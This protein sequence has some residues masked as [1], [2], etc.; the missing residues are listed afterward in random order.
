VFPKLEWVDLPIHTIL[1]Q[2]AES[3]DYGY[4]INSGLTSILTVMVDGKSVDVGLAGTEGFV[5]MPLVAGFKSSPTRAIVQIHGNAF[6]I[7]AKDLARVLAECP[8]LERRLQ[9]HAQQM[10]LQSAQTAACNQLHNLD[11]R[12][13]TWLL[14]R[15]D[16]VGGDVFGLT[17]EFLALMLGMRR[18]SVTDAMGV[19]Q[20]TR[21]V[22]YTRGKVRINNR[23]G[24]K[25][26]ACE[27]YAAINRQSDK[28]D[29]ESA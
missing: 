27:C 14:M 15:Q 13:A 10:S 16:R 18:A 5:G 17:Q 4:F 7:K 6:R 11:Q 21:L 20:K 3:I 2:V 28:W 22:T 23:A 1:N 24:L 8:T 12:L 25:S 29:S 19:L 26:A 9:Q